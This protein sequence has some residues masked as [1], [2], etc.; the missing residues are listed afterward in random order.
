VR[1][2]GSSAIRAVMH[3]EKRVYHASGQTMTEADIDTGL[4]RDL[5]VRLGSRDYGRRRGD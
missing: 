3:P 5:Y 4:L 1:R 2:A